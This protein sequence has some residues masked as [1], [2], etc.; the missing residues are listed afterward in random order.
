M[1]NETVQS[2]AD[3]RQA[4]SQLSDASVARLAMS[5]LAA[6][7]EPAAPP[8]PARPMG[9]LQ[10]AAIV[11]ALLAGVF[12]P[13]TTVWGQTAATVTWSDPAGLPAFA[14]DGGGLVATGSDTLYF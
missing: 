7:G 9:A 13:L 6:S 11:L 3:V 2:S 5:A 14:G 10:N 1:P 4:L 12:A 8:A